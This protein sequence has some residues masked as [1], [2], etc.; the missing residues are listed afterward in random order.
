LIDCHFKL[1]KLASAAELIAINSAIA[2]KMKIHVTGSSIAELSVK[3]LSLVR[4]R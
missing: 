3:Q 4:R 2:A 1:G